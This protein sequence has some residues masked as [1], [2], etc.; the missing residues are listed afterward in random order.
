M[1]CLCRLVKPHFFV[2]CLANLF[3][4]DAVDVAEM[5]QVD[6]MVEEGVAICSSGND[7]GTCSSVKQSTKLRS[8]T[9]IVVTWLVT[10]LVL[11]VRNLL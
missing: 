9:I 5:I 3:A 8:C 10:V 2:I 11:H 6:W 1:V 7:T 4:T